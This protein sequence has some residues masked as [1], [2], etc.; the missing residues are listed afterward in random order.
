VT[1]TNRIGPGV[2]W[3]DV[4]RWAI[5]GLGLWL[6]FYLRDAERH[7]G[8]AAGEYAHLPRTFRA[9]TDLRKWPEEQLPAIIVES[10]GL[11]DSAPQRQ[12]DRT[13]MSEWIVALSAVVHGQGEADTEM[14]A[15]VYGLAL[16]LMTLQQAGAWAD[17]ET[18][19][20]PA[21]AVESVRWE[22]EG[23]DGIPASQ[24]RTLVAATVTFSV[25]FRDV[26]SSTGPD[27]PPPVDPTEDPGDWPEI[28]AT[29]LELDREAL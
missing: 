2:S 14:L 6:P 8:K 23:Y 20:G 13:F 18:Y 26:A 9:A 24:R 7:H 29:E 12:A 4:R 10:P 22:D 28:V 21:L 19:E 1:D 5:A 11:T 15:S 17:L 27:T 3:Y 16:R 25:V